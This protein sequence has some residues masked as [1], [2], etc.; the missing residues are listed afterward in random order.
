MNKAACCILHYG[1]EWL[2]YA[3]RSVAPFMDDMYVFYTP[4]PSHGHSTSLI[5]P[6]SRSELYDIA[7]TSRAIWVDCPHPF[8]HEGQHRTYAVDYLASRG[9]D[10]VTVV[11][12]DELWDPDV[13]GAA[14]AVV[15]SGTARSYRIGMRHFWRSLKWI[16]DDPAMPTRFIKP[17]LPLDA[18]EAYL[19]GE[20]G[21][22]FHMGYAQS[23]AIIKYKQSIHGH[24]AE[25]RPGWFENTFME[26]IPGKGD[27][28]PTCVNYWNPQKYVDDQSGTL[29]YLA[30][31]HPYYN[32][33]LIP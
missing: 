18:P 23:S 20:C 3:L 12:A 11:D 5:N 9:F 15:E 13:L 10:I 30:G 31:D 27:V 28:H 1:R 22:V 6:E 19:P 7:K 24:K 17:R 29:E 32:M 8:A 33:E 2:G 21:K 4:T 14:L 25:W 16:C 26:W